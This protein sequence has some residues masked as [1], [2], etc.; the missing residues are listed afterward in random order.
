MFTLSTLLFVQGLLKSKL[1][2]YQDFVF[3]LPESHT[4]SR[5]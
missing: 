3:L 4:E 2:N 1:A 5:L